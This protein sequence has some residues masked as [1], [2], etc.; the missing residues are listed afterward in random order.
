MNVINEIENVDPAKT[1]NI[2]VL[3]GLQD[4]SESN[5]LNPSLED[6]SDSDSSLEAYNQFLRNNFNDMSQIT[7]A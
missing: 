6:D 7:G 4:Q 5:I 2:V 3:T 1:A